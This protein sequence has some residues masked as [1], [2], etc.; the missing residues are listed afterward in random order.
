MNERANTRAHM[1]K[2]RE[3]RAKRKETGSCQ[4]CSTRGST[5]DGREPCTRCVN[6]GRKGDCI[7]PYTAIDP[8]GDILVASSKQGVK[9]ALLVSSQRMSEVSYEL[10]VLIDGA[11][12]ATSKNTRTVLRIP[13]VEFKP[14]S[15]LCQIIHGKN[16]ESTFPSINT[17]C[18]L[19]QLC[20]EYHCAEMVY[21]Y[22]NDWLTRHLDEP[23][24]LSRDEAMRLLE[25]SYESGYEGPFKKASTAA[26]LKN[27]I[28]QSYQ[29]GDSKLP[30]HILSEWEPVG[31]IL[32]LLLTIKSKFE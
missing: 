4:P 5:C 28:H 2:K 32:T 31:Q 24:S 7:Y 3:R 11:K 27:N 25:L 9:H 13:G 14:L 6:R 30:A 17:L 26:I 19:A 22:Y 16:V 29:A 21:R 20:H 12:S 8:D 10:K 15:L 23:D 1:E 18:G